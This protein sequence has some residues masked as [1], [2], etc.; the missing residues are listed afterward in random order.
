MA[1]ESPAS[2]QQS[3]SQINSLQV[4]IQS[5]SDP[6][7]ERRIFGDVASAGRQ[8]S[9]MS[10][11]LELLLAADERAAPP[12]ADP[13]GKAAI[14]AFRE[15]R[16]QIA[17]EKKARSPERIIGPLESLRA[18]D[19]QAFTALVAHLRSWLAEQ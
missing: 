18:E 19:Q 11:V 16:R 1:N 14:A 6:G 3:Q 4:S 17:R 15:M 8:L 10:D 12:A 5:S 9:R 7:L 2:Q 13:A